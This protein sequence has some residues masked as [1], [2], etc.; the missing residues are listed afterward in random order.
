MITNV[1]IKNTPIYRKAEAGEL[2]ANPAIPIT[3]GTKSEQRHYLLTWDGAK[4]EVEPT[5]Q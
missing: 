4:W 2:G 5:N 3:I 1:I